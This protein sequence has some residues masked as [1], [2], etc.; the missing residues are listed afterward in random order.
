[1]SLDK[2]PLAQAVYC[3]QNI[4]NENKKRKIGQDKCVC[5]V[6]GSL[7]YRRICAKLKNACRQ[8][9]QVCPHVCTNVLY[10]GTLSPVVYNLYIHAYTRSGAPVVNEW[11]R[12]GC[13]WYRHEP[14]GE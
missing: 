5:V 10:T 8:G 13:L 3:L 9:L 1:M 6:S 11:D 7:V 12:A 14:E 2:T 4:K